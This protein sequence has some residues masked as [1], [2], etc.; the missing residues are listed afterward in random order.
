M[1]GAEAVEEVDERNSALDSRKVSDCAEIHNLL[2]VGFGKHSK[3]G[4]TACVNVGMIAENV[5][6]V[7][8]YAACGNMEN[9]GEKLARDLVHVRDH[10]KKSLRRRVGGGECAGC[11][12][13]V[14]GSGCACF[15][16]HLGNLNSCAENVFESVC[17]PLVNIVCHGA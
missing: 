1:R 2:R 11:E 16:L 10:K 8:S 3:T 6:C 5:K 4:L 7:R 12:R 17:R 14:N 13:T 9:R 15:G